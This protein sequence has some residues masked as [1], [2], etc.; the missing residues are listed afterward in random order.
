MTSSI[1]FFQGKLQS[2][3]TELSLSSLKCFYPQKDSKSSRVLLPGIWQYTPHPSFLG[4]CQVL[5][6]TCRRLHT[7]PVWHRPARRP[8]S[9]SP[10]LP[11][12]GDRAF[13]ITAPTL[14]NALTADIH[15]TPTL[16]CLRCL[17]QHFFSDLVV[18]FTLLSV[19]VQPDC[20]KHLKVQKKSDV[21]HGSPARPLH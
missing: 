19:C 9:S 21:C 6:L 7:W 12:L 8:S 4:F 14:W 10:N 17:K 18:C 3:W 13:S 1:V 11:T 2:C 5:L 20:N 15:T 16:T